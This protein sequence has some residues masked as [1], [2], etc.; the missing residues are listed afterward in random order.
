[1][2]PAPGVPLGG[3]P[4]TTH[5]KIDRRA[6]ARIAPEAQGGEGYVA[7]RTPTGEMLAGIWAGLLGVERVGARD[8]F[9]QLGGHSLLATRLVPRG[10]GACGGALWPPAGVGA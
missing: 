1:M 8:D 7:P 2:P 3:L 10:A 9:F 6:L 5:G 4:L